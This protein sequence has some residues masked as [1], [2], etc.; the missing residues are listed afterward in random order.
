M[1]VSFV[2]LHVH[3]E[4]SLA[5]GLI[6]IPELITRVREAGMPA[7]AITD[8]GNA[9][10]A[11]KFYQEAERAGIKPILGADVSIR[12]ADTG[13][14]SRLLL[15]CQ[16]QA[17]FRNLSVLL[18]RSY[19]EGQIQ[20][21]PHVDYDWLTAATTQGLLALSGG[22]YGELG[23]LASAGN[24]TALTARTRAWAQLFPGR[25]YLEI[26]RT[27]RAGEEQQ[28]A[29]LVAVADALDL[30]LV[31]TNDVRFLA[32][33][34]FDAHE[35]R[36]CI[37]D[38]RT[39]SDPRRPKLYTAEQYL[40]TPQEMSVLFADLP[41]ALA[42]TVAVAQRCNLEFTFGAYHLPNYPVAIGT[43]VE[44]LLEHDARSGLTERLATRPGA[45][46]TRGA[47]VYWARLESELAVINSMG[48]AGY[49]LIVADFIQW[50]KRAAIPVGPGRGSGAGSLA[51]F[52]LGIT[53]LDPLDYDLLFERFLNPERVSMPDF[54]I[55]F[56]MDRRDEVIEYVNERYGRDK[57]AQ[58]ITYGTM[59]AKA[60]LRDVGRVLG[61]PYGFVD[62]LAKLVPFDPNMTLDRAMIEE[63]QLK[64]RYADEDDVRA[65]MDLA[66]SL[67]GLSRNAGKHA[68]GIVIA[69]RP[70]TEFMPLYC[71][72]GSD[73][74]VTQFDMSDVE[75]VGLLKFD[76]LGL[77]TLT[78][79]DSAVRGINRARAANGE[80]S[81]DITTLP[82]IDPLT[83]KLVQRA[84]TTAVFQLE[85][86]GMKELIKR[87]QPDSFEDLIALV[88]L[89]RPGPLQSG[90]VDD[91]ID[92]KHGKALVKY[93]TPALEGILKPTYGVI[94]YQE[95]VMQIAQV[96]AGYT[97]GAADLLRRAMGKKKAEE[98]A[99]QRQTFITGATDR[100]IEHDVAA[101]IF[102]L[103]EKFAGYGFNK[104][105][106][107]AYALVA[108]QT[109]WLKAHYPAEFMAAV[110][111]AD[112]D[113]TDKVVRLMDEC[114]QL[115]ITVQ[116]PDI[117]A[118]E[119]RFTVAD[120]RTIRYGLG[121][122][123]GVG[124]AA[125][126]AVAEERATHG[127]YRDLF[128]LCQRNDARKLG[129]R[130][131]EALIKSGALD[132]FGAP[133]RGLMMALEPALQAA[134]Q[135]AK[136]AERGQID[137]FGLA[138][139]ADSSAT[140][141]S[142]WQR[143]VRCDEWSKS[144]ILGWEKETLGLYLSGHPIDRYRLELQALG[145]VRL[146]D[147][148]T[149]RKRVA[150]FIL[151]LRFMK[152]R[153]GRMAILTIDDDTARIE[154]TVYNEALE[155]AID[156]LAVDRLVVLEGECAVDDYSGEPT[157][158]AQQI[159][160]IDEARQ[161]F[162][163]A[164]VIRVE[165]GRLNGLV[166]SLQTALKAYGRGP[167]PVCI[168][169]ATE[170]AQARIRLADEWRVHANEA[171]LEQLRVHVGDDAVTVEY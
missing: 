46:Q 105:H 22:L 73:T 135:Q 47:D 24:A 138:H 1:S 65:I 52:A 116:N 40:R 169:Y 119:H 81:L 2:H 68:G 97:L 18:T 107:A 21:S 36:V 16:D 118:C 15:L 121:A 63:P 165:Q 39:L 67:E 152:S 27:G 110:L 50:A 90:M 19:R 80:I 48:F 147:L 137:M 4:Y 140:D 43:T 95:Q 124:E 102:D 162:A 58:I 136:A 11:V 77:R 12:R 49:F 109:A 76:F 87:L 168:E 88:A 82:L 171:L 8:L 72:Q 139:D 167:C 129:R 142:A 114:R 71:E 74:A 99:Q 117:N 120:A 9:F 14:R 161:R 53:E 134:E 79:I 154:A 32:A 62:Q 144:Q 126:A 60:V 30:P 149:G 69:P 96:L 42:N 85:S 92:R 151:G 101:L 100:G 33:D 31:A 37:Q 141:T 59:A 17:G 146:V 150:G 23:Q 132:S 83:Y 103:M 5:D 44:A 131:L 122:I 128:D 89:F 113:T 56:C 125:V 6:R 55:D 145:A 93:P 166:G 7:V 84:Q 156:K 111:S 66:L 104:S 38:G 127:A 170:S 159:W 143:A 29:A 163:R 86:R 94:L 130:V 10:A 35:A 70:L 108:Y 160:S 153:R 51:A 157:L 148:K 64:A 133:R 41:D 155:N 91:F 57:V 3:S 34:E 25:Y 54:D 112:M 78:I 75:A 106:S 13:E 28:V 115:Q 61:F 158:N 123:K 20:G 98:M 26:T 45:L 164:V